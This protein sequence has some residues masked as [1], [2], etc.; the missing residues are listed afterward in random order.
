MSK[1]V[2]NEWVLCEYVEYSTMSV[3]ID[4]STWTETQRTIVNVSHPIYWEDLN[5][6]RGSGTVI[7]G[8]YNKLEM[9]SIIGGEFENRVINVTSILI[10]DVE[11]LSETFYI[12][13]DDGTGYFL[14]YDTNEGDYDSILSDDTLNISLEAITLNDVVSITF[15]VTQPPQL[16]GTNATL[17]LLIPIVFIGGVLLYF[18]KPFKKD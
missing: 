17:I 6:S 8:T 18:Y 2:D 14:L 11:T 16:T 5:S 9:Y 15:E 3:I 1:L 7:S 13:Y 4:T 12:K 10:N